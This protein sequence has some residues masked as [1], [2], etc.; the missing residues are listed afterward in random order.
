VR[1]H[2]EFREEIT[3]WQRNLDVNLDP[4]KAKKAI[5]VTTQ[6]QTGGGL[7]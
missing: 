2:P 5:D 7:R 4:R 1:S 6:I 3:D